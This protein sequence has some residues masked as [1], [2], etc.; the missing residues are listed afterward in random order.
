LSSSN[1]LGVKSRAVNVL[2][3]SGKRRK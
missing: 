3:R 1:I 2:A